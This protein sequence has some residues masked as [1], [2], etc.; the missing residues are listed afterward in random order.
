MY[1]FKTNKITFM[2][3]VAML[4]AALL[5]FG[6]SSAFAEAPPRGTLLELHSCELYAGGCIVSSE[7]TQGGRYMLRVW[8]FTQGEIGNANLAGLQVALLQVSPDNLAV[9]DSAPGQSVLYLPQNSSAAQQLALEQW[10]RSAAA[11]PPQGNFETRFVPMELT[12]LKDGYQFT[13]GK[14]LA[15]QTASLAS[16]P[17]GSCGEALWYTPRSTAS[18]FTVALDRSSSVSEPLLKLKWDDSGKKSVFLAKFGER[19]PARNLYVSTVDL[20][21]SGTLF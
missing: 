17:T 20:C 13:A 3:L 5:T 18:V 21:G 19:T 9:Q 12:S 7:A 11:M 1:G 10:V 14:Y 4:P 2:K 16:C 6:H 8:N 15:V